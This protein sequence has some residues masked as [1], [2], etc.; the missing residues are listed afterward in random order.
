MSEKEKDPA[1]TTHQFQAFASRGA[2]SDAVSTPK[3]NTG[4]IVG[5]AV[6][7]VFIVF[8]VLAYMMIG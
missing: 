8:A 2:S 6:V 4:L 3:G 5:V 1:A 7:A